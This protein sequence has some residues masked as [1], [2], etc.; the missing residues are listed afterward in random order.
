MNKIALIFLL[1]TMAF[2]TGKPTEPQ[3][4]SLDQIQ[5][6][7]QL[8]QQNQ[9]AIAKQDQ[10]QSAKAKQDQE[11]KQQQ[12]QANSQ[13]T[14]VNHKYR[15]QAPS[16][17][18]VVPNST[19]PLMKCIGFGGSNETGSAVTGWC[20]L[21]R[22]LYAAYRAEQHAAARRFEAAAKAQCSHK[23]FRSDFDSLEDCQASVYQSLELQRIESEGPTAEEYEE[24]LRIER[25]KYKRDTKHLSDMLSNLAGVKK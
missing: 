9:S 11:Q 23:L 4:F 21:Q 8:A 14:N 18:L 22:D 15:R 13:T 16:V 20:W 7:A 17:G 25:E 12:D 5:A 1:P 19:A 2:A 3:V 24:L 10:N 6:Q